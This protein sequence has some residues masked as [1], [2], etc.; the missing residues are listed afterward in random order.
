VNAFAVPT[1]GP[2]NDHFAV[3]LMNAFFPFKAIFKPSGCIMDLRLTQVQR[4]ML[5]GQQ[6][7]LTRSSF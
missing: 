7:L 3:P 2:S 4:S 5:N 6:G 1:F